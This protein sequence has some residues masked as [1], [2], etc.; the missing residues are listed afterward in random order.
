VVCTSKGCQIYNHNASRLLTTVE[1]KKK[2]SDG[3]VNFFT[4]CATGYEKGTGQEF[5][6]VGTS[7]GEIYACTLNG[8]SFNKELG[9]QMTDGSAVTAMASDAKSQTLAVGNSNGYV[10]ILNCDNQG[11]W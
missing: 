5:I 9:I 11:D 3:R 2:L 4:C 10:V 1:S 6:A 7:S 8:A